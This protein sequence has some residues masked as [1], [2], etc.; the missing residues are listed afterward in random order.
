MKER[1]EEK[2][3]VYLSEKMQKCTNRISQYLIGMA[4]G[5]EIKIHYLIQGII[6][7]PSL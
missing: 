5:N 4:L 6:F 2:E 1:K 3:E 7:P